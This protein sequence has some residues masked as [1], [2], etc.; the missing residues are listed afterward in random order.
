MGNKHKKT[1]VSSYIISELQ[2][3]LRNITKCLLEA[4]PKYGTMTVPYD[5][6]SVEQTGTHLQEY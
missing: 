6:E 5:D 1:C 3:K 4:R 2:S